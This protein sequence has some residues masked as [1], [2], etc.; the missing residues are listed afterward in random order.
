V[1]QGVRSDLDQHRAHSPADGS[2][3]LSGG[4]D[5]SGIRNVKRFYNDMKRLQQREKVAAISWETWIRTNDLGRKED[6][7]SISWTRLAV[8]VGCYQGVVLRELRS[9]E[10]VAARVTGAHGE[11]D[12]QTFE[13]KTVLQSEK[14]FTHEA[15]DKVLPKDGC[16]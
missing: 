3:G 4:Q 5:S 1:L 11:D 15:G 13:K 12:V 10:V 6:N 8:L 2:K 7:G 16:G 14:V 9:Q